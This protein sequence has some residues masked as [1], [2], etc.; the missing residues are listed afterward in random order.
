LAALI[1]GAQVPFDRWLLGAMV[2]PTP[3][4]AILHSSTMVKLAPF[5]ILKMAPAIT[6]TILLPILSGIG[7]FT[8]LVGSLRALGDKGLKKILAQSTIAM[9]GVMIALGSYGTEKAVLATLYLMLFHALS[10]A[11]LFLLAGVLEQ[12]YH[13]KKVDDIEDLGSKSRW[14]SIGF[15]IGFLS[16]ALPPF[17]LGVGKWLTVDVVRSIV[18]KELFLFSMLV[19]VVGLVLLTFLY[20]KMLS[21]VVVQ[22]VEQPSSDEVPMAHKLWPSVLIVGLLLCV[23]FLFSLHESFLLPTVVG[24]TGAVLPT[25]WPY[26]EWGVTPLVLMA[27]FLSVPLLLSLAFIVRLPGDRVSEY[28]CGESSRVAR[29]GSYYFLGFNNYT[30]AVQCIG[31]GLFVLL[32]LVGAFG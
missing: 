17:G 14:L 10:K 4:S 31:A 20:L 23:V 16:M 8:L 30:Q 15:A 2:A 3:V 32:V 1:K 19:A 6:H 21:V 18:A 5:L 26:S 24:M 22:S 7:L 28:V 11:L 27:L 25:R 9:L 13:L 12:T 29:V